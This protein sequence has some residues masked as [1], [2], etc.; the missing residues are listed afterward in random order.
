[1]QLLVNEQYINQRQVCFSC[2]LERKE[3]HTGFGLRN[4]KYIYQM[5]GLGVEIR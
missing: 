3:V 5:G 4:L 2:L 1:V